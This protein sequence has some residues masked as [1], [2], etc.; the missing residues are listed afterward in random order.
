MNE[1]YFIFWMF[2]SLLEEVNVKEVIVQYDIY[3]F[4]CILGSLRR[5]VLYYLERFEEVF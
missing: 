3:Y 5:N 2:Y 4:R 1:M